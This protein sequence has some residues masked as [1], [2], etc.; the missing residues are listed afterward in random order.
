M[1]SK[2]KKASN[3]DSSPKKLAKPAKTAQDR[4]LAAQLAL[5]PSQHYC[6][7]ATCPTKGQRIPNGELKVVILGGKRAVRHYHKV[8]Y[9]RN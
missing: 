8:C 7:S 6:A 9:D 1:S 3:D 2:K 5:R 4:E